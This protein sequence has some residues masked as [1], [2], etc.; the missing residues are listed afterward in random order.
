[1]KTTDLYFCASD[2]GSGSVYVGLLVN[3]PMPQLHEDFSEFMSSN[4]VH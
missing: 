2:A 4:V 3:F 1:M